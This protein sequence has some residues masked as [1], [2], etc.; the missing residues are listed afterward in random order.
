MFSQLQEMAP[1]DASLANQALTDETSLP[2]FQAFSAADAV[3]LGLSLRKRFRAT[4]RHAKGKGLVISIQTIAGH[5]L[6]ACTVGD[7]GHQ[8]GIGD[9]SLD[10]WS[11]LE[12]MIS[13]VKRTG[14]S[15][16]YV[17]KGMSAMG[18]SDGTKVQGG[19]FPVW[20]ENAPC[21][22]I[23]VVAC[24]SG[25][26]HDDHNLVA[27]TIRDYLYKLKRESMTE[28]AGPYVKNL[29]IAGALRHIGPIHS[30]EA[31]T[32]EL[33]DDALSDGGYDEEMTADQHL[34]MNDALEEIR[35]VIG[36]EEIS[37]LPDAEIKDTIWNC[38]FDLQE[39][40][41]W[42]LGAH[43]RNL[44]LPLTFSLVPSVRSTRKEARRERASR[45]VFPFFFLSFARFR[46]FFLRDPCLAFLRFRESHQIGACSPP[47]R[48]Y[49]SH[50]TNTQPKAFPVQ[51]HHHYTGMHK[52]GPDSNDFGI[53][54]RS[55][56]PLI[57][58]AQQQQQ[59]FEQRD[60]QMQWEQQRQQFLNGP[61][62]EIFIEEA[63]QEDMEYDMEDANSENTRRLS[64]ISERTE[65]TELSPYWPRNDYLPPP[66]TVST[67]TDSS[68]GNL[69]DA[70]YLQNPASL[71]LDPNLIPV[72]PSGSAVHRLSTYEPAPSIASSGSYASTPPHPPSELVPPIETIPDIPDSHSSAVPP[73]VPPKSPSP[74]K[75]PS[76]SSAPTNQAVKQSKL[77]QLASSR[78]S[79]RTKSSASL[80]TEAVGSIKT[81]P[82]LRPDSHR[83]PSTISSSSSASTV[84]PVPPLDQRIP[85]VSLSSLSSTATPTISST[86]TPGRPRDTLAS[87]SPSSTSLDVRKAV[88]AAMELEAIDRELAASRQAR[89]TPTEKKPRTLPSQSDSSSRPPAPTPLKTA[90]E[91]PST[92]TSTPASPPAA[93][94]SPKIMTNPTSQST[95][96]P[97]KLALLAQAKAQKAEA[98]KAISKSPRA[99]PPPV[100]HL[101]PEHTEY[102]TPIANGS[103][104]TTAI[105]TSYQSLYSLTDPTRKATTDAPFVVPLPAPLY[106]KGPTPLLSPPSSP[107]TRPPS[108]PS[109]KPPSKLALKVKKAQ[110]EKNSTP[111]HTTTTTTEDINIEEESPVIVAPSMFMPKSSRSSASPSAFASVLIDDD[112]LIKLSPPEANDDYDGLASRRRK[113][114]AAKGKEK[115]HSA[116][117]SALG[118][119]T[120]AATTQG[121]QNQDTYAQRKRIVPTIG[122]PTTV[123]SFAFDGPSPD[124]IVFN[125]RRGTSLA[126]QNRDHKD[127]STP[128]SIIKKLASSKA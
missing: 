120:T 110:E 62:Q 1:S 77:A 112:D 78:A 35:K 31:S 54:G 74:I 108:S 11:C 88:Q 37:G 15:S 30:I 26:S 13:A 96:P 104:V 94:A 118:S 25:S 119:V 34:Q 90:P 84:L 32:D 9:V 55:R 111:S 80:G 67:I 47:H 42:C 128:S 16:F 101:P 46:P 105:T 106:V 114:T 69:I 71:P 100:Q 6:F 52:Y 29:N 87:S 51:D 49:F 8:S 68:L 60:R 39:S 24:Y 66:R 116:V 121:K 44:D 127:S 124:D 86:K 83:P 91:L 45:Q 50:H 14:H 79:T 117:F 5:I 73:P 12:G 59:M 89:R 43:A 93:S 85:R 122:T 65:R 98:Q 20:L 4:S 115:A 17:E 10:S 125:A 36:E 28:T 40:L 109:T 63:S 7:L 3:T 81:Y 56:M 18:R 103:S 38:Y 58:L 102:L 53:G 19:A 70:G 76:S 72:S 95:R 61:P 21:C 75:T 82:V 23:A 41:D 126:T 64:T 97:S 2:R 113:S 48:F 107:S 27:T 22:P 92:T 99:K 57:H 33:D 123:S